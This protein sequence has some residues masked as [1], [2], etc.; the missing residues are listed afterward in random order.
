MI[1]SRSVRCDHFAQNEKDDV[2][3]TILLI[4][5]TLEKSIRM[6][7]CRRDHMNLFL[8][9]LFVIM[10]M[11]I[12]LTL[13]TSEQASNSRNRNSNVTRGE[14]SYWSNESQSVTPSCTAVNIL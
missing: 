11:C 10:M 8:L 7:L 9:R 1:E 13:T 6:V 5:T 4:M 3:S 2:S 12:V 14:N